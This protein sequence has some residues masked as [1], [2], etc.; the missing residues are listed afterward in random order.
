[1]PQATGTVLLVQ[2]SRLRLLTG[3]GRGQVFVLGTRA[4]IEP[5]DLAVISGRRVRLTWHAS[6]R[7]HAGVIDDLEILPR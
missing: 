2:E 1:M 4:A 7:L 6:A 5:Q 3:H